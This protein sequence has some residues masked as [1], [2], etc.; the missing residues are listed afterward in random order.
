MFGS[1][2]DITRKL[3]IKRANGFMMNFYIHTY[4]KAKKAQYTIYN[5]SLFT[6]QIF[7]SLVNFWLVHNVWFVLKRLYTFVY[8][9]ILRQI[10][11]LYAKIILFNHTDSTYFFQVIILHICN[12]VNQ[13]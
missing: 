12:Y 10:K 3:I 1:S 7:L 9:C 8:V 2:V 6:L 4:I 13:N 5:I 11:K